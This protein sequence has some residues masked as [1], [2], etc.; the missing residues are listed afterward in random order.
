MRLVTS[1][2][3]SGDPHP[4][5]PDIERASA[6][7][8]AFL[9]MDTGPVPEQFGVVLVLED[10]AGLDLARVRELLSE[11]V[12]AVPRLRQ[13]L[14]STPLGCGGPIW[15]DDADFDI[16]HHV[17]PVEGVPPRDEEALL[18][19]ALSVVMTPLPR[20]RPLW[21]AAFVAG[22]HDGLSGMVLVLHHTLADGIGGLA[23]LAALVDPG[24]TDAGR[25]F[26]AS[27]PHRGSL[28]RDALL[29]KVRGLTG[30]A[31]SW[32]LLRS[33]M[34]AGGGLHPPRAADCSL[35]QRTGPH[36]QLAVVRA[37][38]DQL[39]AAAHAQG[40]TTN[41]AVLVAVAGALRRVLLARGED[42][43]SLM[44]TVPVAGRTEAEGQA[45]GN[46]VSP[47]LVA[48]P[49]TGEVADRLVE[50][51]ARVR[52]LKA[53]ARVPPPIA[54]LGWLFRPLARLGGYR[55]YMNRQHRFHTLVSHLRGPTEPLRFGGALISSGIPVGVAE[56]GNATVYFE[57]LSYAG[58]TTIAPMVDPDHFP[59]VDTLVE[60]LRAELDLI[61]DART[62]A[63]AT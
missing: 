23:V 29:A 27:Q 32:R 9:A 54:L 55:W 43:E 5:P 18:K 22:L 53:S 3:A 35:L 7:D 44:V 8:R 57:V 63:A 56:G 10:A 30:L 28:A 39:R 2:N 46:M 37:D 61:V 33:S 17:R 41:D 50:V 25:P 26:P 6:G 48:V 21:S 40:A 24:P 62:R 47:L 13:K 19:T 58:T 31:R 51:A 14:V 15:V 12:V 60:G 11:R 45:L 20:D 34:G 1:A 52:A 38:H 49:A 4:D 16:R 42:V 59:D 36:R